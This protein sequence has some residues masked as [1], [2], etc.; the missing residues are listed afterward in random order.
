MSEY[1]VDQFR[2]MLEGGAATFV[3]SVD[4]DRRLTI[5]IDQEDTDSEQRVF[6]SAAMTMNAEQSR[7]FRKW[8]EAAI[9]YQLDA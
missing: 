3:A 2:F 1:A 5:S 8:L 6:I 9:P 4:Q 7:V